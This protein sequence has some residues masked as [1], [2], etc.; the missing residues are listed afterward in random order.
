[1]FITLHLLLHRNFE[2]PSSVNL[3]MIV[4]TSKHYYFEVL[5][6]LDH[7]SDSDKPI[8][9]EGY[10]LAILLFILS[11]S[12]PITLENHGNS[13]VYLLLSACTFE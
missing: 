6:F 10:V 2:D 8:Y 13:F 5:K 4:L 1:M 11:Y 7:R 9:Y 12:A 3:K